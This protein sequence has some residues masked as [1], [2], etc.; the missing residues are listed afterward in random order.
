MASSKVPYDDLIPRTEM[1]KPF[2]RSKKYVPSYKR[3][4][5]FTVF[6]LFL[7][8]GFLTILTL[9][10]SIQQRKESEKAAA[11]GGGGNK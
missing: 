7:G 3:D 2:V 1:R 9:H 10:S 5:C 8:A 4:E 11:S 6:L